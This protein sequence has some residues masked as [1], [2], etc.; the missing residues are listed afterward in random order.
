[1]PII[2]RFHGVVIKMYFQQAEHN[3]PHFHAAYGDFTA[4]VA[5][6][7]GEVLEGC[8]PPRVLSMVME[9]MAVNIDKLLDMWNTQ[10]FKAIDPLE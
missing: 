1:M 5:I 10:E 4:E 7:S 6:L 3:P 2:S 8:L 9:W